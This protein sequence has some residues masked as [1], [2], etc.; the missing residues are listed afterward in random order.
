MT[1]AIASILSLIY[2][3]IYLF[4]LVVLEF[5]YSAST[6]LAGILPFQPCLRPF[7]L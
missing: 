7:L 6:C 2:L 1:L 5:E 3:F 4:I